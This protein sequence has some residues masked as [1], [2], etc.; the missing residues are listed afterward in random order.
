MNAV[1][2][3]SKYPHLPLHEYEELADC[4]PTSWASTLAA[5]DVPAMH[6]EWWWRGRGLVERRTGPPNARV[7]AF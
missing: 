3:G 2:F 7:T 4:M 1:Q 5:R 6:N